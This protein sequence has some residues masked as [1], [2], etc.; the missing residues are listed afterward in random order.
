MIRNPH[1]CVSV[2]M[3]KVWLGHPI[4]DF[5]PKRRVQR[6]EFT[7]KWTIAI[8][9]QEGVVGS[10]LGF[11]SV[12]LLLQHWGTLYLHGP[13]EAESSGLICS[14]NTNTCDGAAPNLCSS[15]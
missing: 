2:S 7:F 10:C 9:W 15:I 13:A 8:S 1:V 11:L 3:V 14:G 5:H 4:K 12:V 6:S